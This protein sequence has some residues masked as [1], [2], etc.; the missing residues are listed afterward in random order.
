[1]IDATEHSE[2]LRE[3]CTE[4]FEISIGVRR[5]TEEEGETAM[6]LS[7]KRSI[8]EIDLTPRRMVQLAKLPVDSAQAEQIHY[9]REYMIFAMLAETTD[10]IDEPFL[11]ALRYEL[12][13]QRDLSKEDSYDTAVIRQSAFFE[14]YSRMKIGRWRNRH[15]KHLGWDRCLD[16]M[17]RGEDLITE[18]D[19][20]YLYSLYTCRNN[21]AHD[22]RAY[23]ARPENE[24]PNIRDAFRDG[25][26]VMTRLY[27]KEIE[28]TYRSYTDNHLS[29]RLA[30][31]WPEIAK[32]YPT[33]D[34]SFIADMKINCDQ[35][36]HR[37]SVFY[38]GLKECPRCGTHHD[39][40]RRH[41]G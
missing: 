24:R 32:M 29:N 18:E 10:T 39:T 8:E 22:W 23:V 2:E 14:T 31:T 20:D 5:P 21:F 26:L 38:D 11:P 3:L 6:E 40:L 41:F 27:H 34:G 33:S 12:A 36:G 4:Y 17:Y 35:C 16:C 28:Q 9:Q 13:T 37:F 25:L 30:T 7:A 1:M 19:I 15:G